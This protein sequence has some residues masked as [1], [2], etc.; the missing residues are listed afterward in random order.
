MG[1][2]VRV[3]AIILLLCF[4]GVLIQLVNIQ[5][6]QQEKLAANPYNPIVKQARLDKSRGQILASDGTVLAR[7]VENRK[8]KR[9]EY[10]Y[11]RSYPLGGLFGHLVGFDSPIYG[12]WGIEESYNSYL[13][14]HKQPALSISELLNPTNSTNSV[15][16]TLVPALQQVAEQQLKGRS[17]AIVAL[18]PNTGAILAMY[19][20]PAFDPNPL[21]APSAKVEREAWTADNLRDAQG[22][23]PLNGMTYQRTFAPGS[24]FK[25]VTSA[26]ALEY[27]PGVAAKSYPVMSSTPLPQTNKTLSNFGGSSCGGTLAQMLPPSCDTGFAL[28]GL[29][30]GGNTMNETA[31][32]FGFTKVP[33]IDIPG[34]A[35]SAFPSAATLNANKPA[36][37]YS[38]IGQQD[39]TA[40]ALQNA[41]V[42]AAFANRGA[43]MTPHLMMQVRDQ[44]GRLIT[45]YEPH[46][47]LQA[48]TPDVASQVAAL[49]EQVVTS[50]TAGSV[51]FL[52]QDQ[53]AAK[54]GTAQTG[55]ATNDTH[56]WMILF[57]PASNPVVAIAVVM[58]FQPTSGT[59]AEVAGP[60]A[61]CMVEAAL[62]IHAKQPPTGTDTT[63]PS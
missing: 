61:R 36:L 42:A 62:A 11:Q 47:W 50:G 12:R 19:S 58:P 31:T 32:K 20:N 29:D 39:V 1:S 7:S 30:L 23:A 33:P 41:L 51:G 28:M 40:T 24:T 2:R 14:S 17:G 34:A 45:A 37:A 22:F 59:G 38:A 6:V 5:V 9:G 3:L 46:L 21:V 63:C 10:R 44:Q 35:A 60:I 8:A 56:N 43:I 54:T 13:I 49:M 26:A 15:M 4:A 55:N 53:V 52:P 16:L 48:T 18:D 25:T 27:D 57:A